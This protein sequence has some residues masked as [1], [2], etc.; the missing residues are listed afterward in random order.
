MAVIYTIG[1]ST[2]EG[3]ELRRLLRRAGVELLVDVR[4]WPT[5][6]RHPQF[7]REELEA[8]LAEAG[9]GYRHAEALGGMRGDPDPGSPNDGWRSEGFQAYADHLDSDDGREAMDRLESW[10]SDRTVAVMCAEIV[11]WR[12]HRQIVADHLVARGHRVRHI[13]DADQ[14][15]EHDLR[16]MA[17][18]TDGGR[19]VYPAEQSELFGEDE[20]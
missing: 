11:P 16:E 6:R 20:T 18:V 17:R 5:S 9:I 3:E 13:V 14:V 8:S 12:C 7:Q 2:R 10:A 15:D 4:R 19:V 1:H